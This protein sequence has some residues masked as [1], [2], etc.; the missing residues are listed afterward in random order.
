MTA[1]AAVSMSYI[2][3][4]NLGQGVLDAFGHPA[5]VR[6]VEFGLIA[7]A[8]IVELCRLRQRKPVKVTIDRRAY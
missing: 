4:Q 5:W 7:L 6:P 2:T 8:L 1:L 3:R